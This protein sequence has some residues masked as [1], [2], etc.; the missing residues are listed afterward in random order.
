MQDPHYNTLQCLITS[1]KW[2]PIDVAYW[3]TI[4]VLVLPKSHTKLVACCRPL[5]YHILKV[6]DVSQSP[7]I[8]RENGLQGTWSIGVII[9]QNLQADKKISESAHIIIRINKH[10]SH[11]IHDVPHPLNWMSQA[12]RLLEA[13]P[14]C[15]AIKLVSS[16]LTNQIYGS[17]FSQ[18]PVKKT[19]RHQ[20]ARLP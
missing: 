14:D 4:D 1:R 9:E 19:V 7:K 15:P 18:L 17:Q 5:A 20:S 2:H 12:S 13:C 10:Y 8:L 11:I 16:T 6:P 3:R